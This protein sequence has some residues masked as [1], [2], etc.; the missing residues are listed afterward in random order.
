MTTSDVNE[1]ILFK[2][3]EAFLGYKYCPRCGHE[4]EKKLIDGRNRMHC[5][6]S[7]CDFIYYH[8]PIPA[9]GAIII[10]DK[11]VLMVQRSVMPKIGWWCLPAGFMEWSEHSSETAVRELKEETGLDI[12]IDSLF[13][14]YTG[15]DDPRMNAVLIL[16]LGEAIGGELT[17]DDDAMDVRFFDFD[18]LPEK[19]AFASHIQAL[20]DY[21]ER[22]M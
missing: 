2:R 1:D 10:K 21:R 14:V 16:Y 3:K 17:A 8:N 5:V 13:E 22:Y 18:K 9:A 20:K 6:N 19:I 12:K 4:L 15:Q 11:K 7:A